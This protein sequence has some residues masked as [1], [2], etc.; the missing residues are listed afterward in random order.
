LIGT[1]LL[2][3][4]TAER[5][6]V[7]TDAYAAS[8]EAWRVST[9]GSPWMD[10]I[11]VTDLKGVHNRIELGR[12]I[13]P[14]PNGHVVAQRMAGPVLAAM[15]F[16]LVL[17]HDP[18]PSAFSLTPG[19]LAGA[20]WTS[21]A[22]ALL[23]LALRRRL[24]DAL[25]AAAALTF[26]FATPTWAVSAN[27][28]W[29]HTVTQFGLA[30]AAYMLSRDRWWMAGALFGIGMLG[31]PH[32][33]LVA[34]CVGLGLGWA[35]RRPGPVVAVAVPTMASLAALSVWNHWMFGVWSLTGAGYGGKISQ[36]AQGY[37][38]S[39][40]YG[41][42]GSQILNIVGFLVSPARGM[43]IWTPVILLFVPA[44]YRARK[45]VP[46][47]SVWL[48]VG[49]LLYT[50]VQL[51][52]NYFSGGVGFYAYRY[53]LE[54]LTCLV[55]LLAFSVKEMRRPA[56]WLAPPLIAAQVAAMTIGSVVEAYFIPIDKMWTDNSFWL[57]LR[58]QPGVVGVWLGLCIAVGALVSVMINRPRVVSPD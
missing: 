43:L 41:V 50:L 57:S 4:G 20:T 11:D 31:R 58:F 5:H 6:G 2:F 19:A 7:G 53:G 42:S 27:G 12:W 1:L 10:G 17:A 33:A 52:V 9:T 55:P 54:L 36:A 49:G 15:P 56:R 22:V 23:F 16:Y 32:L 8:A 28:V 25:A 37:S 46:P 18:D 38:G 24:S 26:A 34:A 48:A 21:A 40:E 35:K 47:W 29:T 51:R 30:G 39:S 44:L 3:A 13:E 45:N 14:A